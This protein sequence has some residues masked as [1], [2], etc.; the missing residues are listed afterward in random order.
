VFIKIVGSEI[1]GHSVI[2]AEL[3]LR[4]SGKHEGDRRPLTSVL[5]EYPAASRRIPVLS[6]SVMVRHFLVTRT[7]RY[8]GSRRTKQG[9]Q[10]LCQRL[11]T[12]PAAL[13]RPATTTDRRQRQERDNFLAAHSMRYGAS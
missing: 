9:Y 11:Q 4:L 2:S 8:I 7:G 3:D 6:R 10:A 12:F 1:N 13:C 5:I